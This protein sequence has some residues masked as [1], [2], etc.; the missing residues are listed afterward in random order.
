M[1]PPIIRSQNRTLYDMY[2]HVMS[3]H[4]SVGINL[5]TE[6]AHNSTAHDTTEITPYRIVFREEM[7]LPVELMREKCTIF[8][9]I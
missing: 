6:F 7:L 3:K 9:I 2:V 4:I 5:S 8:I 1:L